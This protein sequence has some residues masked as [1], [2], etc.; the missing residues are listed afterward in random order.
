MND[1]A[2]KLSEPDEYGVQKAIIVIDDREFLK[3]VREIELP[4]AKRA[5]EPELTG[6]YD[7]L[8]I[9]DVL[10]PSKH[11]FGNPARSLL[12]YDDRIS[13]LECECGCEGCWPLLMTVNAT[14]H[15]VVWSDFCQIHRDDWHYP[16]D[17]R[18]EFDLQQ[19]EKALKIEA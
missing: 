12:K 14:D 3:I 19:V 16:S 1:L 13:I 10:Y 6:Q 8:N 18:F 17:F 7:Y 4:I 5:S 2:I 11:L 9:D 15:T